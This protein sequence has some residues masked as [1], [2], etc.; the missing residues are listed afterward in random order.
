MKAI[1][2]ET[3][4][5][6]IHARMDGALDAAAA[7]RLEAHLQD[8]A[9]CRRYSADALEWNEDLHHR[10]IRARKP[11]PVTLS[12]PAVQ[13]IHDRIATSRTKMKKMHFLSLPE[14]GAFVLLLLLLA[15]GLLLALTNPNLRPALVPLS[16]DQAVT[17]PTATLQPSPTPLPTSTPLPPWMESAPALSA[18]AIAPVLEDLAQ[19]NMQYWMRPGWVYSKTSDKG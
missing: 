18:E 13:A 19:K 3:A 4:Q 6:M 9:A 12:A 1:N 2:H 11:A 8:C 15:S 16:P 10:F 14:T 7:D 17:A 5:R